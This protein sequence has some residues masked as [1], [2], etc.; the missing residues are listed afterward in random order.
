ML[1]YVKKKKIFLIYVNF[2][3]IYVKNIK[4]KKN[5]LRTDRR[6]DRRTTQNYS[7]EPHKSFNPL[8]MYVIIHMKKN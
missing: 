1:I 2:M 7:S 4:K 8:F 5:F 6:T 3:L